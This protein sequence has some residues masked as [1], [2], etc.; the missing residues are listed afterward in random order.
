MAQARHD[1]ESCLCTPGLAGLVPRKRRL[2]VEYTTRDGEE[3]KKEL[4]GIAARV[5]QHELEHLEGELFTDKLEYEVDLRDL[6]VE[7]D[8]LREQYDFSTV[9]PSTGP[10]AL[11]GQH[12]LLDGK[13]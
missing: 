3:V 5:F 7:E 11:T 1:W 9:S 6:S 2:S 12:T 4:S 10:E 8:G 13:Q